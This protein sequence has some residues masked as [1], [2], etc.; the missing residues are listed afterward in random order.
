MDV[1]TG[2]ATLMGRN[3]V[4]LE[5]RINE[6]RSDFTSYGF[7]YGEKRDSMATASGS[8]DWSSEDCSFSDTLSALKYNTTYWYV[9]YAKNSDGTSRGEA[10]SFT[11]GDFSLEAVDLGLSVAWANAN[12]GA[13]V[14]E[15]PGA[16]CAWDEASSAAS[17]MGEGWRVPTADE[18]MELMSEC[19]WTW[20]VRN[21]QR[22]YTVTADNGNSIFLPA[23]GYMSG[24]VLHGGGAIGWYWTSDKGMDKEGE[25]GICM[26]MDGADTKDRLNGHDMSKGMT[27]RAVRD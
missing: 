9:A 7:Y 23:G 8:S 25:Y 20:G 11:T 4:R 13:S 6:D 22:G 14:D 15:D 26:R 1:V 16:H 12:V 18:Y 21:G 24:T 2:G 17:S 19:S 5:G 27:V 3:S 10:S